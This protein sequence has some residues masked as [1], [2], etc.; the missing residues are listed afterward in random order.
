MSSAE[1]EKKWLKEQRKSLV[2]APNCLR[3]MRIGS[4]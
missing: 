2:S 3:S 4:I 1:A